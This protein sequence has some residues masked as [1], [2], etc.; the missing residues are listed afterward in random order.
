MSIGDPTAADLGRWFREQEEKERIEKEGGLAG[1]IRE[2]LQGKPEHRRTP[3][4]Q[5]IWELVT[6][7]NVRAGRFIRG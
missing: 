6:T 7:Y 5:R 3:E 1:K 4:E 2:V